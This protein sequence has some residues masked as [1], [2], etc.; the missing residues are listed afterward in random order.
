[1]RT[2]QVKQNSENV[3]QMA[4]VVAA[5]EES[6]GNR[7]VAVVLFGSQARHEASQNSDWD[8]LLIARELPRNAFPRHLYLKQLL[9]SLWRGKVALLAKT[10]AEFESHLSDLFLDIALDG[11]ILYDTNEYM[12]KR[13]AHLR[14]LI[15][16]QGL[17]REKRGK[18][19]LW[20]WQEF[21]GFN[22]SLEWDMVS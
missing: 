12:A 7:L 8:L 6:L 11:V 22:W 20:R 2:G 18:E 1:M 19:L 17:R 3:P 15:Q 21:P 4:P 10:P 16:S 14:Q 13:L 9:P 5:L